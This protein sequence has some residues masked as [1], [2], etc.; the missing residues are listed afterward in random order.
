MQRWSRGR[1]GEL[2]IEIP[3]EVYEISVRLLVR[4]DWLL[5]VRHESKTLNTALKPKSE[6]KEGS[7][8]CDEVWEARRSSAVKR[9]IECTIDVKRTRWKPSSETGDWQAR[10]GSHV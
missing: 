5:R 10:L 8:R 1:E 9:A 3:H 2:E 4:F 6:N 7:D